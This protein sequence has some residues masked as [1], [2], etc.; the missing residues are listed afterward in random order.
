MRPDCGV[1]G[2]SD[3]VQEVGHE[4]VVV[5]QAG[6]SCWD[7][8]VSLVVFHDPDR[9]PELYL[10]TSSAVEWGGAPESG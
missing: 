9:G 1:G 6:A 2:R 7:R 3:W 8:P 5:E 10:E 4:L